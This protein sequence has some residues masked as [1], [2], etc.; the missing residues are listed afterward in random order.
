M[1]VK[2]KYLTDAVRTILLDNFAYGDASFS[3]PELLGYL[4]RAMD[5]CADLSASCNP[6]IK[7]VA[8]V[9]GI[10]QSLPANGGRILG[11]LTNDLTAPRF[12]VGT[13]SYKGK[14]APREIVYEALIAQI[15]SF[16]STPPSDG[17]V[18]VC[19][20]P[21]T[22]KQFVVYPPNTGSGKMLIRYTERPAALTALTDDFPLGAEFNEP[23]INYILFL[24][25]SRDG[26][27]TANSAR[28]ADFFKTASMSLQ[29]T[30]SLKMTLSARPTMRT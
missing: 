25:L 20:D 24:C 14:H 16:A 6:V 9:S 26:E 4:N 12:K 18:H 8:M 23:V 7:P 11:F 22:P 1:S 5:F 15:P 19:F 2:A 17:V 10:A 29:G 28:S 27:D 30:D 3:D 13:I 21:V